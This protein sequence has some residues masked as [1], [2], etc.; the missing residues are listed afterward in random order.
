LL[1]PDLYGTVNIDAGLATAAV[2]I[3]VSA[4]LDSGTRK[5]VLI[6]LGGGVFEPR[7]VELGLRGDGHVEVLRGVEAGERVVV[8]GN[9]LIDAESNFKA[10]L[11]SF[12]AHAGHGGGDAAPEDSAPAGATV[13]PDDETGS[14]GAEHA[15]H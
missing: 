11:G 1:K 12:G 6:E 15:G 2:S 7:E 10:A 14:A 9:F 13:A 3:P 4:V 5:A 8:N